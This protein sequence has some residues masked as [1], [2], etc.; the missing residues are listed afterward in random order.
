MLPRLNPALALAFCLL[1]CLPACSGSGS[2]V[3]ATLRSEPVEATVEATEEAED[4]WTEHVYQSAQR[5]LLTHVD[6]WF[7]GINPNIPGRQ[8]RNFL[9][10]AAGAPL[11]REKCDTVAASGYQGMT[12]G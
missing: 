3:R 9:L 4:A 11:Y 10:Y 2:P 6:S 1:A 12:F 7:N 8:P 5:M